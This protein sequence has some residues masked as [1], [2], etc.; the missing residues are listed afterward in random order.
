MVGEALRGAI[1][2]LLL[3]YAM[4]LD[5]GKILETYDQVSCTKC[6][7]HITP[8]KYSARLGVTINLV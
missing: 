2:L 3:R 4:S 1:V 5:I 7:Y 6:A 8:G